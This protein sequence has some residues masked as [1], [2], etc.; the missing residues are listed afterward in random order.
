MFTPRLW[1]LFSSILRF[2]CIKHRLRLATVDVVTLAYISF[3]CG[4]CVS[5]LDLFSPQLALQRIVALFLIKKNGAI[6]GAPDV[7]TA[8]FFFCRITLLPNPRR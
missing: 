4:R 3:I 5:G 2:H 6:I 8:L 1:L 7:P